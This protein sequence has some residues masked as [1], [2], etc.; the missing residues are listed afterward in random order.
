M[1][2]GD[3]LFVLEMDG[4][5]RLNGSGNKK[6]VWV[7]I[8]AVLLLAAFTAAAFAEE[9]PLV[10]KEDGDSALQ[11]HV[12]VPEDY[13][14]AESMISLPDE[15][16]YFTPADPSSPV[17]FFYYTLGSGDPSAL[18]AAAIESYT[19]F[20][21]VFEA[22]DIVRETLEGRESV[23]LDYTC[24]YAGR[25]GVSQVYEQ[26]SINY[27]MIDGD[28]FI[29]CIVSMA[30]DAPDQWMDARRMS[31]VRNAALSAIDFQ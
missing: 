10:L 28:R 24:A 1:I 5:K 2:R 20:Y 9:Y 22:E 3:H 25:D 12:R 26:T 29:A 17:R 30:F 18:A 6:N 11:L 21:D 23:R 7:C 14:L 13:Q 16:L 31:E 19:A 27:V 4:M 8:A 15:E